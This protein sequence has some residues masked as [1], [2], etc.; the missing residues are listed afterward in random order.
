M[1]KSTLFFNTDAVVLDMLYGEEPDHL[2]Q[3]V[4]ASQ[5]NRQFRQ[6]KVVSYLTRGGGPF[7]LGI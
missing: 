2:E 7:V 6:E 4:G 3:F 5:L 1:K